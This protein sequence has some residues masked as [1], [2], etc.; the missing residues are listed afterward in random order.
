MIEARWTLQVGGLHGKDPSKA[1]VSANVCARLKAQ[2]PGEAVELSCAIGD[3]KA[4]GAP[5]D[6]IA[7][8]ARERMFGPGGFEKF[9]ERGL[10]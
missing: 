7:E 3:E 8:A 10:F 6:E 1:D 5:Y 9:A 4:G 2:E